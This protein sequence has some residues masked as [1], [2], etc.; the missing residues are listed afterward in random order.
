VIEGIDVSEFQGEIDFAA[1]KAA[2]AFVFARASDGLYADA[3]FAGNHDECRA[4]DLP[5]GVYHFFRARHGRQQIAFFAELTKDRLGTLL[6][7]LDV[8]EASFDGDSSSVNDRLTTIRL[9]TQAI[10]ELL[11]PGELCLIYTNQDT[12]NNYLGGSDA[13]AGHPLWLAGVPM[14]GG[15]TREPVIKQYAL[16]VVPGITGQVDLD[17]S[18]S[19]SPLERAQ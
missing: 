7:M 4:Q 9:C 16:G 6:P 11:A 12:W 5:F 18:P 8:E 1:V 14:P 3:R 10:E 2:K 19:L 13:F 15:F 17:Q